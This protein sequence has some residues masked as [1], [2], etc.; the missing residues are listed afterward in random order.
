[1]SG[2]VDRRSMF[3]QRHTLV[4][5]RMRQPMARIRA[6]L[7]MQ[8]RFCRPFGFRCAGF[9][10]VVEI[11]GG[12]VVSVVHLHPDTMELVARPFNGGIDAFPPLAR[13]RRRV[14]QAVEYFHALFDRRFHESHLAPYRHVVSNPLVRAG[15]DTQPHGLSFMAERIQNLRRRDPLGDIFDLPRQ[16]EC[17]LHASVRPEPVEGRMSVHGIAQAEDVVS[18]VVLGDDLVDVPFGDVEDLEMEVV[19]PDEFFAPLEV[20]LLCGFLEIYARRREE[21][22]HPSE[23]TGQQ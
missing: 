16:I 9:G 15:N 13:V 12:R 14:L 5:P 1:M 20:L 4:Q 21:D 2:E 11:H 17:V 8:D 23:K 7:M 22:E 10:F 6:D 3:L 19:P 18:R